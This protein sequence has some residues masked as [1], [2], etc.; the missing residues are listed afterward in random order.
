MEKD[1]QTDAKPRGKNLVGIGILLLG[2]AIY[3]VA[4][5]AVGDLI[6]DWW[7]G[8]QILYYLIAGIIWIFPA[9]KLFGWMAKK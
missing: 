4:A 8:V 5:A 7:L 1:Y 2:L 3:A 6:A 9:R